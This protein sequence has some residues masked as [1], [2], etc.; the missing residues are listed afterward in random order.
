MA[1]LKMA[2]E[3]KPR[4]EACW[5]SRRGAEG[6]DWAGREE[7]C[8]PT[9]AVPAMSQGW[10]RQAFPC[11]GGRQAVHRK[12]SNIKKYIPHEQMD[13]L[14]IRIQNIKP[15]PALLSFDTMLTTA[16]SNLKQVFQGSFAQH[17]RGFIKNNMTNCDI[18]P[19]ASLTTGLHQFCQ[20]P[21]GC[22]FN[23]SIQHDVC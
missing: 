5:L 12:R 2:D 6:E 16:L 1:L 3:P 23:L 9:R 7:L 4:S 21:L 22:I 17:P 13:T 15:F 10:Q 11:Q 19:E 20:Q 18:F 8:S 14:N